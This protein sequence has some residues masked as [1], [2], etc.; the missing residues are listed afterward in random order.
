M[1]TLGDL[2]SARNAI[3]FEVADRLSTDRVTVASDYAHA[4]SIWPDTRLY[5]V[6]QPGFLALANVDKLIWASVCEMYDCPVAEAATSSAR[7]SA[8]PALDLSDA[9]R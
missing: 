9:S 2:I 3:G 1:T 4:V 5:P 6:K 7:S 8:A